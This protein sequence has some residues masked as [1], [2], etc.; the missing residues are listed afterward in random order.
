M[1]SV[2][3][4]FRAYIAPS[5]IVVWVFVPSTTHHAV[6]MH[7]LWTCGRHA[8][9]AQGHVV[10]PPT[11]ARNRFQDMAVHCARFGLTDASLEN[12]LTHSNTGD[13]HKPRRLGMKSYEA[14]C[15]V[16]G[17]CGVAGGWWR[18]LCSWPTGI[19]AM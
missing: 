15:W 3:K 14:Q 19:A 5:I 11:E 10:A 13:D 8:A 18:L 17:G 7:A 4:P 12:P 16:V 2:Q 9:L 1:T 6:D